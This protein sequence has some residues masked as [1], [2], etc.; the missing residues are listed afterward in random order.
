LSDVSRAITASPIFLRR[1]PLS[2]RI[3]AYT[4]EI[5]PDMLL[6]IRVTYLF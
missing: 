2:R 1:K 5:A 3:G 6:T 4:G